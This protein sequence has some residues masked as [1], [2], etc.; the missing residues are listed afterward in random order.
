[1]LERFVRQVVEVWASISNGFFPTA[2]VSKV[3]VWKQRFYV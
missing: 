2:L 1:M 3:H